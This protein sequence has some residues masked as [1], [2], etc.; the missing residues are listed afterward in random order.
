MHTVRRPT[1]I[2]AGWIPKGKTTCARIRMQ[3]A[4][5]IS[6]QREPPTMTAV[7]TFLRC[8]AARMM[9]TIAAGAWVAAAP[10][11]FAQSIL[12]APTQGGTL[13]SMVAAITNIGV[14]QCR[15]QLTELST[16]GV[17]GATANDLLLDWDHK[18]VQ[19][20]PIF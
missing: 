17:Q 15:A 18:R 3:S 11:A 20:S 13:N 2:C 10:D 5:F 4:R 14:K 6:P 16:L 7:L 19:S 9:M 1:R 8:R 12:A